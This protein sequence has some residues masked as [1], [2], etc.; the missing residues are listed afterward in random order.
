MSQ[1]LSPEIQFIERF[2]EAAG[3]TSL[4]NDG[5]VGVAGVTE[6]GP[7]G[8]PT[9]VVS[10]DEFR[11][12]FG[13]FI[14]AKLAYWVKHFF[15]NS[16]GKGELYVLR[17]VHYTDIADADTKTSAPA[18]LTV[19]NDSPGYSLS[20]TSPAIATAVGATD[21]DI[22]LS[23]E[24]AQ[25]ISIANNLTTGAAIAAAIQAAVRALTAASGPNQPDYDD[26]RC[27]YT[28]DGQYLLINGTSGA[29]KT[30]VVTDAGANNMADD[31]KLGVANGGTEEAAPIDAFTVYANSDGVWGNSLSVVIAQ[32]NKV[33]T[34]LSA[35]LADGG[36]QIQLKRQA[37]VGVGQILEITDAT[38]PLND[39]IYVEVDRIEGNLVFLRDAVSLTQTI[40]GTGVTPA[41]VRSLE[42]SVTVYQGGRFVEKIENLSMNP[43]N[44]VDYFVT[45]IT[46]ESVRIA[47][48]DLLSP[49]PHDL[50][51]PST[52]AAT[53]LTGGLD[54]ASLV[55]DTDFVGDETAKTGIWAFKDTETMFMLAIPD[56]RSAAV[57]SAALDMAAT[58]DRFIVFI[59]PPE[60]LSYTEMLAYIQDNDLDSDLGVTYWPNLKMS[61]PKDVSQQV[62]VPPSAYIA[63]LIARNANTSGFG[64]GRPPAGR[65]QPAIATTG[66]EDL[67]VYNKA[68][69][70]VL[71]PARI[72]PIGGYQGT[73]GI[74]AFGV[75]TLLPGGL[76]NGVGE[77]QRRMVLQKVK[78][79]LT[80]I[81]RDQLL[82]NVI[83]ESLLARLTALCEEYLENQ[84]I[85]GNLI[86]TAG[87]NSYFVNFSYDLNPP[88]KL[89]RGE[90]TGRIGIRLGRALKFVTIEITE[91]NPQRGQE[92]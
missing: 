31:L 92:L 27:I 57:H 23:G 1:Y 69:R 72:N 3:I 30:V 18:E 86:G 40:E 25:T 45:R 67:A 12:V 76:G 70:D 38:A 10:Y 9:R 59:D 60:G 87:E 39:P 35:D 2:G 6:K 4:E 28:E 41:T 78:R 22:A 17:I 7:V 46:N 89:A 71:V 20:A 34:T 61:N 66:V 47:V 55:D 80:Q 24:V 91:F 49:V 16:G 13:D 26:F 36:Q 77:I 79:N 42:F 58:L 73:T 5:T 65:L 74:F 44:V 11:D 43:R 53:L 63:G 50:A 14:D 56:R 51:R 82:S 75:D 64:L 52:L 88:A 81:L 83:D 32:T 19:T 84:R 85:D 62:L 48:T 54:G 21:L 8:V 90:V 68:V 33:S 37:G 29:S 15:D